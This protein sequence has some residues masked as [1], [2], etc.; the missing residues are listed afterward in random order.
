MEMPMKDRPPARPDQSYPQS[1]TNSGSYPD[2]IRQHALDTFGTEAKALHWLH[3]PNHLF[4]G[5]TPIEALATQP[6]TVER[7][8]VKIDHG[9]FV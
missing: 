3:R 8:L 6:D 4:G 7:E 2:Q 1:E 9:I 5:K